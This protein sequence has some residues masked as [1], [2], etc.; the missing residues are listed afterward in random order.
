MTEFTSLLIRGS[1]EDNYT[2]YMRDELFAD[3]AAQATDVPAQNYRYVV[4]YING[5]YWGLYSIREH[6][7]EDYF[8][9]HY[10]VD[11]DT[12]DRQNGT[13][14]RAGAWSDLMAYAEYNDLSQ[15]EAYAYMQSHLDIPE[16]IDWLILQCYSG[17]ID[18]YGNR[19]VLLQP[20]VERGTVRLRAGGYGPDH[21][22]AQHLYRGL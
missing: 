10:G 13:Y 11:A 22:G 1:L 20:P 12:V 18:V 9:S 2:S 17:N 6:H 3:L 15:P 21:D 19:S 16:V 14:R 5:E 8:A 7:T 4:L